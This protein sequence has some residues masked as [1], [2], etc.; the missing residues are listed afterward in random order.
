MVANKNYVLCSFKNWDESLWLRRL[1][2][3][4]DKHLL[5]LKWLQ[6]LIKRGDTSGADDICIPQDFIF[7]LSLEIFEHL[8]V[9]LVELSFLFSL[10]HQ[11][12]HLLELVVF[13]MLDLL[14]KTYVINTRAY[15]LSGP[16]TEPYHFNPSSTNLFS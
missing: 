1:S 13:E 5:E 16:S 12:L 8:I 11:V 3:F 10:N 9:L 15:R 14:M 7:S 2:C 6:P 4:I